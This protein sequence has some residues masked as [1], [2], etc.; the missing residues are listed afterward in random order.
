MSSLRGRVCVALIL[1]GWLTA[2]VPV[3]QVVLSDP[4]WLGGVYDDADYDDILVAVA[5]A[6]AVES[7]PLLVV[8]PNWMVVGS[9]SLAD[10]PR[11]RPS[12]FPAFRIRAP[13]DPSGL[14]NPA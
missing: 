8:S 14:S 3:A 5:S 13:P 12:T 6:N 11:T 9:T 7:V 10:A 2:V 4:V 1:L